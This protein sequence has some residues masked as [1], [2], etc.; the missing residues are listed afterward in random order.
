MLK[1]FLNAGTKAYLRGLEEEFGESTN[2]IRLELNRLE[3]AGMISAQAEGNKKVFSAN[4]TH[5]LFG[6]LHSILLKYVGID[7]II[8]NV[9][10]GL[11]EVNK[12]YLT[13]QFAKGLD[14]Q[15]IDLEIIG[16]VKVSYLAELVEKAQAALTRKIRYVV[17]SEEE[18]DRLPNSHKAMPKLLIWSR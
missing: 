3:E 4:K 8:E 14:D 9:L 2:A 12:V 10:S 11:G 17:F 18:Y 6:E 13:G 1:F 7:Q 16:K 5:P 15:I